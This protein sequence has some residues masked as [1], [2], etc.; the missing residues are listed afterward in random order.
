[1]YSDATADQIAAIAEAVKRRCPVA[2]TLASMQRSLK[3]GDRETF[4]KY[5]SNYV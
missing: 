4:R 5:P 1:V 2:S 3:V